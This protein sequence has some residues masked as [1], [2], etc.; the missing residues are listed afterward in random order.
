M[1]T[2]F[3]FYQQVRC[4]FYYFT[5][6][7][8][9]YPFNRDKIQQN[10]FNFESLLAAVWLCHFFDLKNILSLKLLHKLYFVQFIFQDFFAVL[11]L[12]IIHTFKYSASQYAL[13]IAAPFFKSLSVG[14]CNRFSAL[15]TKQQDLGFIFKLWPKQLQL[16]TC[17][18]E[19]LL[20]NKSQALFLKM[21]L[22]MS[23]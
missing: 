5:W 16:A 15:Q 9:K 4:Y 8:F 3:S 18:V 12:F 7:W 2:L 1:E 21:C 6:K 13:M 22:K 14:W 19:T 20:Y 23:S 10:E 17:W 11:T